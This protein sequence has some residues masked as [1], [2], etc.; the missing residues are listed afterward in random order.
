M[1]TIFGHFQILEWTLHHM[2]TINKEATT[3]ALYLAKILKEMDTILEHYIV[4]IWTLQ[5][6]TV[7]KEDTILRHYVSLKITQQHN[8]KTP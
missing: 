7:N 1:D 2:G 8:K 5:Q 6:D 4:P 3:W